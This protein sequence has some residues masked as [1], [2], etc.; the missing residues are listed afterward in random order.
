M[1]SMKMVFKNIGP[2][3]KARMEVKDLTII[4][5]ANNTGKTY[6]AYTLYGFLKMAKDPLLLRPAYDALPFDLGQAERT[7]V[8][9]GHAEFAVEDFASVAEKIVRR[10]YQMSGDLIAD[11]FSAPSEDFAT[12][13]FSLSPEEFSGERVENK[14]VFPASGGKPKGHVK[15]VYD[16]GVLSLDSNRLESPAHEQLVRYALNA[17]IAGLCVSELPDPFILSSERFGISLFYKE[18]DFTK[19]RLLETIQ[20][21]KDRGTLKNVDPIFML[22]DQASSRYAQPIKDN[23]DYT[24]NLGLVQERQSSLTDRGLSDHVA[25]ITDGY[26]KCRN[27]DIR[28]IA[29]AG[30]KDRLDIPLHLASSSARGLSD[31][32]FFL[33]HA[34][35]KN[36][37]LII[38]EPESHLDTSNQIAMARLIGRCVNNGL[39]VLITTHSDYLIKEFNNLIMLDNDFPGKE[40][41]LEKH[42]DEYNE[43]DRLKGSSVAA[44][45]CEKGSLTR[46]E[47]DRL[48]LNMPNFDRT[49]DRINA[50][51]NELALSVES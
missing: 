43:N 44:Y 32:Y 7:L 16:K 23:I 15:V 29:E 13:E 40:K 5:G 49:I 28:F 41:F 38:D 37:L 35:R 31:L 45:I 27:G 39:K 1:K 25:E 24:R 4:A 2:V 8:D 6:L 42:A 21:L 36:Q 9:T 11:I 33:K 34:A 50:I 26:F 48:G 46:C 22:M 10:V 12:A 3:R 47:V 30:K 19:N 51:S 17:A 14:V 20:K 18:L